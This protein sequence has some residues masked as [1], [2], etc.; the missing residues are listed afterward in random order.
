Y[1]V[2]VFVDGAINDGGGFG[3]G[4]ATQIQNIPDEYARRLGS[5]SAETTG[6][7]LK[8]F[9]EAGGTII[10]IGGSTAVAGWLGLPVED[11]LV[12]MGPNGTPRALSRDKYYVPGSVLR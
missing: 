12:E 2:L 5:L 6:P 11:H 9:A 3:R 1:D 7:H 4:G 8:A 10:A